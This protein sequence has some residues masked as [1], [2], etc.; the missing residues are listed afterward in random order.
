MNDPKRLEARI[1]PLVAA[2]CP[3]AAR[4]SRDMV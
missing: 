2:A 1:K 3:V 4:A